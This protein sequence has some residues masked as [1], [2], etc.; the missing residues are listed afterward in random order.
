MAIDETSNSL[1]LKTVQRRIEKN[2]SIYPRAFHEYSSFDLSYTHSCALCL[3]TSPK[4]G[5]LIIISMFQ[6][7]NTIPHTYAVGSI[8][9]LLS[10][11]YQI[12]IA[13]CTQFSYLS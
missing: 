6:M 7:K 12:A 8:V 3:W 11:D 9:F 10:N 13:L 2:K 5:I 1:S 4:T